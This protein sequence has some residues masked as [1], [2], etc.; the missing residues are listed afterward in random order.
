[1]NMGLRFSRARREHSG[2][3]KVICSNYLAADGAAAL[4][5]IRQRLVF[6]I[7]IHTAK[8][9]HEPVARAGKNG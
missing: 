2:D 8:N 3:K 6:R 4:P 1:M 5:G 9:M 7:T